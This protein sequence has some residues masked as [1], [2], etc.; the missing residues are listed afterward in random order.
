MAQVSPLLFLIDWPSEIGQ[1]RH[2]ENQGIYDLPNIG[3]WV[4]TYE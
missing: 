1:C 4:Q 3:S 2:P